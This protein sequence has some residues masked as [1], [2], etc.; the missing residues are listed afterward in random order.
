MDSREKFLKAA[1]AVAK[2]DGP[3]PWTAEPWPDWFENVIIRLAR[4]FIPT[5]KR[6]DFKKNRERFEGYGLA[7]VTELVEGAQKVETGKFPEGEVFASLKTELERIG[8]VEAKR[9]QA[10]LRAAASL[11]RKESLEFFTAYVNGLRQHSGTEALNRLVDNQ[12][13]QICL[14]LIFAR[15]WIEAKTVAT[16]TVLFKSFMNI[17]EAFPGQKEFFRKNPNAR[18][19]LEQHFRKICTADKVKLASRGQP[20]RNKTGTV[21]RR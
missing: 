10:T 3:D 20:R 18:R 19:S 4:V 6:E 8:I 17:R 1:D 9:V 2:D 14:F 12:T 13:A 5:L 11:P 21:K 7:F 15:P 16:V